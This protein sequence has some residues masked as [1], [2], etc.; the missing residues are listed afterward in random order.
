LALRS[1]RGGKARRCRSFPST[2]GTIDMWDDHA[3]GADIE[4]CAY[5]LRPTGWDTNDDEVPVRWPGAINADEDSSRYGPR[6]Q[7]RATRSNPRQ[8][9][10]LEYFNPRDNRE[11]SDEAR[12]AF[13]KGS[14]EALCGPDA[15]AAPS[16]SLRASA[17]RAD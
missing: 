11:R 3:I 14:T 8:P 15:H 1:P 17:S 9:R 13:T 6:S 10:Y 16:S 7:S 12:A 5:K 2:L 4:R